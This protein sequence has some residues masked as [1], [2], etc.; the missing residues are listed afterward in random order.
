M[1]F[2]FVMFALILAVFGLSVARA[3]GN[4]KHRDNSV[5]ALDSRSK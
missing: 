4:G 2:R 3:L 5:S 1:H